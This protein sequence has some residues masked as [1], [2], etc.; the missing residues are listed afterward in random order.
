MG[1]AVLK[2]DER[3]VNMIV[4]FSNERFTSPWLQLQTGLAEPLRRYPRPCCCGQVDALVQL[5][6][7]GLGRPRTART[8]PRQRPVG[9]D[10]GALHGVW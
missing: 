6:G 10:D 7:R 1:G 4:Q 2:A 3:R 5:G 9:K 8:E